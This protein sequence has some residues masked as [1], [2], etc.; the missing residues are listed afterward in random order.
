[1]GRDN[2]AEMKKLGSSYVTVSN[3]DTHIPPPGDKNVKQYTHIL[4]KYL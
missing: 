4:A 2:Q 1:M 3:T